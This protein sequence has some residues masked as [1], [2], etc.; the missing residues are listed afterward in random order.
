[1]I[2]QSLHVA[3]CLYRQEV[4]SNESSV[5]FSSVHIHHFVIFRST[6]N[7]Y[8]VI[9]RN[10]AIQGETDRGVVALFLE[11]TIVHI[12]HLRYRNIAM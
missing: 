12:I 10:N 8:Y 9:F 2:A 5:I 1:M 7:G 4:P 6:E 11:L 3:Q